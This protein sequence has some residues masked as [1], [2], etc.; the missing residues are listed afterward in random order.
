M[1]FFFQKAGLRRKDSVQGSWN[2]RRRSIYIANH[3]KSMGPRQLPPNV[4]FP[5]PAV[6]DLEFCKSVALGV[7]FVCCSCVTG[8][9]DAFTCSD[10]VVSLLATGPA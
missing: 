2:G 6:D 1:Y 8:I 7:G 10:R 9:I 4:G 3:Y 5:S